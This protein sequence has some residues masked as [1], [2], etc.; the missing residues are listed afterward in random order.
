MSSHV[1]KKSISLLQQIMQNYLVA[2]GEVDPNSNMN[3]KIFLSRKEMEEHLNFFSNE[4]KEI[5]HQI[6]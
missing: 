5:I 4:S 2:Y 1:R 6:R 3:S